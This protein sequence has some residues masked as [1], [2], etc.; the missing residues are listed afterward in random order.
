MRFSRSVLACA[1]AGLALAAPAG[2]AVPHTVE[3]GETLWSIASASNFTT[4]SL[5]VFNGLPEDAQ[6]VVGNTI[7]IPSESEAAAALGTG[8]HRAASPAS[9]TAQP[10]SGTA[11]APPVLGALHGA[12]GRH[13]L[14]DRRP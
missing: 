14:G 6:V 8:A 3:P 12:A 7:Q 10:A 5:A 4:R 13:A 11:E 1:L 2:A 9:G